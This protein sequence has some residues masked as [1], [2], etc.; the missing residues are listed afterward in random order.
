MRM[1]PAVLAVGFTTLVGFAP[2]ARAD[3][4]LALDFGYVHTRVAITDQTTI[5][6]TGGRFAL[7]FSR[8]RYFH[9]GA[10]VDESWLSGTTNLPNGA[11]ARTSTGTTI[12]SP[13]DGNMLALK[14][15]AGVHT[16]AGA[17]SLVA[18]VAGGMRDTMVGSDAGPDVAGRKYESLFELRS[19]VELWLTST[20]TLGV[21]A[22]ADLIERENLTF[23]VI[24]SL[25]F[26]DGR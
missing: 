9:V 3:E 14:L 5:D 2:S 19:R 13:L 25:H 12:S 15:L 7:R 22:T 8:G 4:H 16:R 10:E 24:G 18:D 11:V 17:L 20:A 23:G 21:M 6:G 1:A 26:G